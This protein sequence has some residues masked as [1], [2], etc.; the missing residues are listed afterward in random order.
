[1]A[2]SGTSIVVSVPTT[3]MTAGSTYYPIVQLPTINGTTYPP[4]Q[5]YN[6]PNDIFTF[7]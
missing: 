5:P 1:M 4:S 6:E 7:T 2:S 3:T